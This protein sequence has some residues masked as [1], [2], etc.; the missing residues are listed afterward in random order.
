MT[1]RKPF[2]QLILALVALT[3]IV[4]GANQFS[5]QEQPRGNELH[6]WFFDIGQGDSILID[7]PTH[8]QI[9]IDGGPDQTVLQRLGQALPLTD[10]E[11][12]LV[13]VTHNHSDHLAGINSVLEH[14]KV[15]KIWVSG[16]IHTTDTYRKF[17]ELIKDKQIPTETVTAGK[18]V[19]FGDLAGIAIF[20]LE[21]KTGQ[22]PDNQHDANVVTFWQYG[23]ETF[24][25]TGDAEAA[26]EQEMLAKGIVRPAKILKVGHH[27]SYTSTSQAFLDAVKPQIAVISVGQHN[28]FG[29]P[30]Q[31]T[32]DRLTKNHI[33][34]LRTDHDGTIRF[35]I[36][37]DHYLSKTGL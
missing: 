22:M 9:L 13:I 28:K 31:V 36:W 19:Q 32:L 25:L 15:D 12:N 11:I 30:H 1:N 35:S 33:P 34:I 20:P 17:L 3:T 7:T 16:A 26:H 6:L 21:D 8:Q 37:P 27:G 10:K 29:H 5:A 4:F 18:T 14:Y 24:L 23:Q 2:L